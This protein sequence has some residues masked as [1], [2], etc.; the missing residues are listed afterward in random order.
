MMHDTY[1]LKMPRLFRHHQVS[2]AEASDM[3]ARVAIIEAE[4]ASLKRKL[5]DHTEV[6]I[7]VCFFPPL[8][9]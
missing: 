6:T 8:L 5:E 3:S 4:N 9:R 7:L 1:R 2:E